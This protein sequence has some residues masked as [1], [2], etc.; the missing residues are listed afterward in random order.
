MPWSLAKRVLSSEYLVLVLCV[1]YFAV[2]AL[3]VPGFASWMNLR[4]V[5]AY[6]LPILAVS[7]GLTLVL[8]TAGIDLSL[9][10][11][12]ALASVFGGRI[13]SGEGGWL[14]G[15]P[16]AGPAAMVGM[17]GLGMV[18]GAVN[19]FNVVIL[20]IPPF[21]ATLILMMFG[22]GLAIWWTQSQKIFALPAGFTV[23]ARNLWVEALVVLAAAAL[24]HGALSRTLYGRWLYA[25]G[26]NAKTALISGVPVGLVTFWAYVAGG[27]FAGLSAILFTASLETSDP[28]MARN[29]LLD[30]VG[31][32]VIG[33]T[34]LYGGKGKVLWT[35][36]GV[37]FLALIDNSL[38]LLGITFFFITMIKGAVILV[39]ALLDALR[40]RWVR[41]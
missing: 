10:S 19:G 2:M 6:M 5:L 35:V 40:N 4:T 7:I 11:I 38:N 33:G 36:Y 3:G 39:A 18:L 14:A 17:L 29:S 22:G 32:T 31:A 15:H 21:M 24:A 30:I 41:A 8:I 26:Q 34:S 1:V 25:V 37:L 23:V 28:E 13:M 27:G 9:T 12:I 20:R 16:L